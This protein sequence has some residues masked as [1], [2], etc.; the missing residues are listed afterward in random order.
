M[1]PNPSIQCYIYSIT[2]IFVRE[3]IFVEKLS[4]ITQRLNDEFQI[5]KLG[6]DPGFSRFIP[7][8]YDSIGFEWSEIFEKKFT[9]LFNG[10]MMKG[11]SNV[12]KIFLAVFPTDDVLERFIQEG[13]SGDLLFMHHPL[14]MECGDPRGKPGRG[15]VPIRQKYLNAISEKQLSIYTCHIPLDVHPFLS[16]NIAIANSIHAR[17]L[18]H[19]NENK[20]ILY[21]VINKTDTNTLISKLQE[22]FHIPYVDFEG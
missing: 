14:L 17:N 11:A 21:G 20:Y 1:I 16:T 5:E 12:N 8:V 2:D 15:F 4:T 3:V 9:Q 22:I 7:A 6:K 19:I 13:E 10:L 18:E